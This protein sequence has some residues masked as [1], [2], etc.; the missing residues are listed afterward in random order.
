MNQDIDKLTDGLSVK[1]EVEVDDDKL[2]SSDFFDS[3]SL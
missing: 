1:F 2:Q 3:I